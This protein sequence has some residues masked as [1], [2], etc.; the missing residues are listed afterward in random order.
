MHEG[1]A[2]LRRGRIEINDQQINGIHGVGQGLEQRN[3]FL[4]V[5]RKAHPVIRLFEHEAEAVLQ[6]GPA[7]CKKNVL[8]GHG[9][10]GVKVFCC[11]RV[12]EMMPCK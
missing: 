11:K 9:L 3:G 4:R 10:A 12:L 8:A 2:C 5:F 7:F 6:V 1:G